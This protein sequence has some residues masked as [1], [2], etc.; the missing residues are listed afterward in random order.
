MPRL[1]FIFLLLCSTGHAADDL[2]LE[3][4][5]EPTQWD[6]PK[7]KLATPVLIAWKI[8][9][10][11]DSVAN[12]RARDLGEMEIRDQSGKVLLDFG[13]GSSNGELKYSQQNYP[14]VRPQKTIYVPITANLFF[15]NGI[16]DFWAETSNEGEGGCFLKD[17]KKGK[18]TLTVTY[19]AAKP[20]NSEF[21]EMIGVGIKSYWIGTVKS[22]IFDISIN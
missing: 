10:I 15:Q 5:V 20:S 17:L 2:K 13:R 6:T 19:S 18:Y 11:G 21:Q 9:N 14:M 1:F 3:L 8:T 4:V 7:T 16:L 22:K 12:F